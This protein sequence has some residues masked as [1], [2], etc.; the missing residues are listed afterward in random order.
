VAV[1]GI[2]TQLCDALSHLH[3]LGIVHRD[4]KLENILV[5]TTE[6][7]PRIWLCDLGHS[8]ELSAV[9]GKD[10]FFGTVHYAAPEVLAGPSWS[11][12]ADVWRCGSILGLALGSR[13]RYTCFS[14]PNPTPGTP[15]LPLALRL[16]YYP[17]L[18]WPMVSASL[19][20]LLRPSSPPGPH[21]CAAL[22][23]ACTRCSPTLRC[24]GLTAPP[25]CRQGHSCMCASPRAAIPARAAAARVCGRE[26]LGSVGS[27]PPLRIR[28]PPVA[29]PSYRRPCQPAP[30]LFFPTLSHALI[31]V[32]PSGID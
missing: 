9:S 5:D 1:G 20:L 21:P 19:H 26:A 3:G 30:S 7:R 25:I 18:D 22:A 23:R 28:C 10:R 11:Y 17:L 14:V 24:V 2:I 4:V 15:C 29:L 12:G 8:C 16:V 6:R 31:K 27:F 32:P 13:R